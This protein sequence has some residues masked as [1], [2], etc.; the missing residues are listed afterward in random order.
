MSPEPA[1]STTVPFRPEETRR[2]VQR[3]VKLP[4]L[5]VIVPRILRLVEDHRSSAADLAKVIGSDTAGGAAR[6]LIGLQ[7]ISDQ[8]STFW[9]TLPVAA[10]VAGNG[11]DG[12]NEA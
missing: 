6:G 5:P 10:P 1:V 7:S 12:S 4:T 2:L 3:I 8:G 11:R 9:F